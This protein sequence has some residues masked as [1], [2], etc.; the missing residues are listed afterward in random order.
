MAKKVK[1]DKRVGKLEAD[2]GKPKACLNTDVEIWRKVRGDYYSP[3]ISVT[4]QGTICI[5]KG[6]MVI[7]LP[8]EEW[9]ENA[10]K[11]YPILLPEKE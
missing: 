7:C 1:S 5:H 4:V 10:S 3:S 11:K 6:G 9:L 2:L 8:V